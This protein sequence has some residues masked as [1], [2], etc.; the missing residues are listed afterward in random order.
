MHIEEF[1]NIVAED[2]NNEEL[3]DLNTDV[4]EYE[5]DNFSQT[6]HSSNAQEYHS[7][8]LQP[9]E[10]SHVKHTF[11]HIIDKHM[12]PTH[13][14]LVNSTFQSDSSG[15]QTSCQMVRDWIADAI[16]QAQHIW[17]KEDAQETARDAMTLSSC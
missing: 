1:L 2:S 3:I 15:A 6:S 13:L 17:D 14:T 7:T 5:S 10:D 16:L 8:S 12:N 11:S 4:E 9:Q